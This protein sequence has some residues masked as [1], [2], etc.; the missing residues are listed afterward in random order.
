M[1][2]IEAIHSRQ[3]VRAFKPDP[4]PQEIL[5]AILQA[6]LRAP[7]WDNTQP[8][9]FAVLGGEVLDRVRAAIMDKVGSGEKINPDLPWPKLAGPYLPCPSFS[10]P[11]TA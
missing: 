3:S 2:V 11:P 6:A 1:D 10:M 7:S 9:E 5:R 4:V 8:W